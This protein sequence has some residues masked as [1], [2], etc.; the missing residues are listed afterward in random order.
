MN[1]LDIRIACAFGLEGILKKELVRQGH[2]IENTTNGAVCIKGS[3]K[4]AFLLNMNLRTAN[5]VLIKITEGKAA[6]F[7]ELFDFVYSVEWKDFLPK[8]AKFDVQKITSVSSA[9]FSLRDCQSIIKK[10]AVEK[11]KASY[12]TSLIPESGAY[13]PLEVRIKN[14]IAEIYLNTSGES[15][16]KRGYRLNKG[17]SPLNE[18]LA[19]GIALISGYTGKC[20]FADFMC[21]SG[22]IAIEAAMIASDMPPGLGRSFAMEQWKA[23]PEGEIA[24]LRQQAR[25]KIRRPNYRILASDIDYTAVRNTEQNAQR[26]AVADYIALQ[27]MD[28]RQ[29]RSKAARGIIVTN[30][31]YGERLGDKKEAELLYS[32]MRKVMENLPGWELNVITANPEFQRCYGRKADKNRKL[33]NGNMLSYL[34]SYKA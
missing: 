6:T 1:S 26:C 31:P 21:G 14:D 10:A 5:R 18:T 13:F 25:E 9:L 20:E 32:D 34:Y 2:G 28:M 19:A 33:Y 29:F 7:D 16:D 12:R 30:P 11:M 15:L 22:T 24:L 3:Y 27:K 17:V 4:D 8:D 23:L